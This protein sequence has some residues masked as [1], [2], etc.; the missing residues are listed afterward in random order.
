MCSAISLSLNVYLL[1]QQHQGTVVAT[2]F[3]GDSF[4]LA[5][6]RRVRLLGVDAPETGRPASTRGGEPTRGRCMAEEAKKMLS[7]LVLGKKVRIKNTVVDD[8]GRLVSNVFVEDWDFFSD[9]Q[10]NRAMAASG[11]AKNTSSASRASADAKKRGLGIYSAQ[12]RSAVPPADCRIKGN[13]EREIKEYYLTSCKYY[14]QV[15][16]DLSFGDEWFCTESEAR[17]AGFILSK[18]CQ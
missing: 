3:D 1:F 2:I 10:V 5:D 12:C 4:E 18:T 16:V 9:S 7:S 14:N 6:G 13:T 11:L 15:I 8:Y 17:D